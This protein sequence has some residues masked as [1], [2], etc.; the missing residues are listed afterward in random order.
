L[1]IDAHA[2][3]QKSLRF[4]PPFVCLASQMTAVPVSAKNMDGVR[5]LLQVRQESRTAG[6]LATPALP[7]A[8]DRNAAYQA[9]RLIEAPNT[10]SK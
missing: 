4:F 5:A 1:A 3:D 8:R 6:E 9:E 10:I 7:E 2:N